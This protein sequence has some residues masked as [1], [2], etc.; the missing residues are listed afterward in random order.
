M[1]RKRQILSQSD[2]TISQ[3]PMRSETR[4]K[5]LKG[6]AQGRIWLDCLVSTKSESI[7]AI[8]QRHSVSEK[9]IRS[10]LSLAF[11]APDIIDAAIHGCGL[12]RPYEVAVRATLQA[13]QLRVLLSD[14][15]GE[16]QPVFAV[17]AKSNR[18]PAK[19]RAFVE[20]ARGLV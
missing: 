11:L 12:A 3:R 20:F 9:T 1:V 14:W 15:S 6:I 8:A 16:R 17:Y 13:G 10:T 19:V 7:A 4:H 18:V 5:L 2:R